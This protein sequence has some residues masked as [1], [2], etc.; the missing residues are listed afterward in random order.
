MRIYAIL[1]EL[2]SEYSDIAPVIISLN[3]NKLK[4][5]FKKKKKD[6]YNTY[7]D[8][9]G[10]CT[11]LAYMDIEP[12]DVLCSELSEGESFDE[13]F[14]YGWKVWEGTHTEYAWKNKIT[15]E[16]DPNFD[17]EQNNGDW[18]DGYSFKEYKDGIL[19]KEYFK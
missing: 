4:E 13:D 7:M 18:E 9:K 17:E 14:K 19:I 8:P 2:G 6:Y 10:S 11:C 3:I 12:D 16:I 15:G 1:V 5:I